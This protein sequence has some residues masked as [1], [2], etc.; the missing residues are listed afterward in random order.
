MSTTE[1]SNIIIRNDNLAN[2]Q[3]THNSNHESMKDQHQESNEKKI[4]KK[5]KENLLDFYF[6]N[7]L[8]ETS[9]KLHSN[10][11]FVS[12]KEINRKKIDNNHLI[13]NNLENELK[14]KNDEIKILKNNFIEKIDLIESE[15]KI[16]LNQI[17]EEFNRV[18]SRMNRKYKENINGLEVNSLGIKNHY[19]DFIT[20]LN[21]NIINLKNNTVDAKEHENLIQNLKTRALEKIEG[22]KNNYDE[23][24]RELLEYFDKPEYRKLINNVNF[25]L[26]FKEKINFTNDDLNYIEQ[27]NFTDQ[28]YDI[29]MDRIK[30]NVITAECDYI[31][32]VI[33]L[34][35]EYKLL[36]DKIKYNEEDKF[37]FIENEI[38]DKF[39]VFFKHILSIL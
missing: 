1:L 19:D 4:N 7:Q 12:D 11:N 5:T 6:N 16:V 24:L 22:E 29:W 20:K 25:Y 17:E 9:N 14:E 27:F 8:N 35:S 31:N 3:K 32:G 23:K 18:I 21:L 38:K 15:N 34:E 39:D 10:S 26:K 36:Y 30:L 37:T 2:F 13:I 33:N 28:E